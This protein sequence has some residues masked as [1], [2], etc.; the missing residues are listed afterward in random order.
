M[1]SNKYAH[2]HRSVLSP[3]RQDMQHLQLWHCSR[4]HLGLWSSMRGGLVSTEMLGIN[5]SEDLIAK[6]KTMCKIFDR[7]F[8]FPETNKPFTNLWDWTFVCESC[9]TQCSNINVAFAEFFCYE[10]RVLFGS[11]L[12]PP[13]RMQI[14]HISQVTFFFF[15]IFNCLVKYFVNC[16]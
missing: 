4:S 12:F 16:S 3:I 14:S 7:C 9:F 1:H 11:I 6:P 5:V 15:E 2:K 8:F 13:M 10:C